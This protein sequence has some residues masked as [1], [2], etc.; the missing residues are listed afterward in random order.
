MIRASLI[1]EL[2]DY[3]DLEGRYLVRQVLPTKKYRGPAV[4]RARFPVSLP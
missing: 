2:E 1:R 4:H 3:L